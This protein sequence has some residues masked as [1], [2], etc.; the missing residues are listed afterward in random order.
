MGEIRLQWWRDALALPPELRTGHPVADAVRKAAHR[1]STP[2]R[3]PGG[4]DRRPFRSCSTTPS[5]LTDEALRDLLWKTEGAL[6]AL[7]ARVVGLPAR[8]RVRCSL[9]CCGPGLRAGAPA[10]GPAANARRGP[11]ALG[12]VSARLQPACPRRTC[13]RMRS[14]RQDRGAARRLFCPN[15][16]QFGRGAAI[17]GHLAA[18]GARRLPSFGLGRALS[19]GSRAVGR[20]AAARGSA[21][22][23]PYPRVQDCRRPSVWPAVMRPTSRAALEGK[24]GDGGCAMEVWRHAL[25]GLAPDPRAWAGRR[26]PSPR[27]SGRSRTPSASS[28]TRPTPRCIGRPG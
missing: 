14:D 26:R 20:C 9:C 7:G 17:H 16:P 1:P 27:S 6:F 15:S 11:C 2:R 4:A 24:R 18:G 13:S 25:A 23:A 5:P 3:P 22:C 10:A 19:A 8:R 12:Q 21:R 28:S